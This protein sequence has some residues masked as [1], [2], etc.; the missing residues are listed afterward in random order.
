M[1]NFCTGNEELS[2]Q[3]RR[4]S[5]HPGVHAARHEEETAEE[6]Y[7]LIDGYTALHWSADKGTLLE[8]VIREVLFLVNK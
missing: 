3:R 1:Q 7:E 6:D 5:A 2:Q 8:I 4:R